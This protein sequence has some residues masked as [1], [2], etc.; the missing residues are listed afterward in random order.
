VWGLIGVLRG[1]EVAQRFVE[2]NGSLHPVG[3]PERLEVGD[4][5]MV[6]PTVGDIH[7]VRNGWADLPSISIHIYGGNIGLIKRH[8]FEET[9]SRKTFISGYSLPVVPNIWAC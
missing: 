2:D 1:A 3:T 4:I 5:D 8:A 9:G 7:Q 6:S